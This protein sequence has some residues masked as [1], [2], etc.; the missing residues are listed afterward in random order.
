MTDCYTWRWISSEIALQ[1]VHRPLTLVDAEAIE[2]AMPEHRAA[3]PRAGHS[4]GLVVDLRNAG[5]AD[6]AVQEVIQRL[7]RVDAES[8]CDAVA[9]VATRIVVRMQ[10]KRLS[11]EAEPAPFAM[12]DSVA[13]AT[14]FIETSLSAS[15]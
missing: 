15:A 5:V 7:M 3:G 2:A 9:I 12:F 6:R 14:A 8:G 4:W 11:Q 10:S 1:T 13:G